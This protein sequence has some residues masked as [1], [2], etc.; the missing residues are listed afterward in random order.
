MR[1]DILFTNMRI[2]FIVSVKIFI[3]F[4]YEFVNTVKIRY[5]SGKMIPYQKDGS[6]TAI[7]IFA[8]LE[9]MQI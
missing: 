6:K 7:K 9:H 1:F 4:T 3:F 5:E 2:W 8:V